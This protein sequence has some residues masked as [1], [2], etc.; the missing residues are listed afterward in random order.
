[1]LPQRPHTDSK[2]AEPLG[3]LVVSRPLGS[4]G[5]WSLRWHGRL[6]LPQL[7]WRDML[8]FGTLLNLVFLF[9]TLMLYAQRVDP[10]WAMLV[11]WIVF[12][13][14][15]FLAIAVWRH[16]QAHSSFKVGAALWLGLTF[17]I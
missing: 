13:F 2:C 8:G 15:V 5:F 3:A 1:M 14:N 17:L 7:F 4:E 16:R 6:P 11:H 10:I 12:S 9:V